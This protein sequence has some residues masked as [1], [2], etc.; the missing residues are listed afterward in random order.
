MSGRI[1]LFFFVLL[2]HQLVYAKNINDNS[3]DMN[4]YIQDDQV[5]C[6]QIRDPFESFNRKIFDFNMTLDKVFL[7][8][9]ARIYDK[10]V[11]PIARQMINN[12]FNN[13][14]LTSVFVNSTLQGNIKNSLMSFWRFVVNS[15]FGFAGMF[16]VANKI[17]LTP[18]P[19]TIGDTLAHYGFGPGPYLVLPI[20]GPTTLR[21]LG[22]NAIYA[23]EPFNPIYR[24]LPF[25]YFQGLKGLDTI[26]KLSNAQDMLNSIDENSIDN[27]TTLKS[28]YWQ[29]RERAVTYPM[30]S[31]CYQK[32]KN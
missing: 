15:T 12:F 21:D 24:N 1:Y 22:Q 10:T 4:L 20:L 2:I 3:D 28:L 23:F 14:N 18:T 27:Y 9:S 13:L 5:Y 11:P 17:G 31:R 30:Y 25:I 26:N 16:D 29:N 19:E 6:D 8:P 7:K 32:V